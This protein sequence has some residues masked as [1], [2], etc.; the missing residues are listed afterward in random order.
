MS[1]LRAQPSESG[2]PKLASTDDLCSA[3]GITFSP[4][5][6]AAITAP[7]EPGVIIAGAG[8]GK[9]TVM[10]ARVV[11]LVGTGQVQP[12]QVLGLT[13]TRKAAAELSQ[14]VRS[15]L[16]RAG[17]VAVDGPDDAGEEVVMTYDAFAA[18]LV[19]DHGL[20]IAVETDPTMITGAAR[21][22][23]ASRAVTSASGPFEYLSRLRP[24]SV[25][26]RVLQLD[27][28]L[29]AHLV[30]RLEVVAFTDE[31]LR[32]LD[33]APQY[34]GRPY[35]IINQARAA[36]CE[37]VELLDL[38]TDYQALKRRLGLVEFADQMAVAA[39]L[40][41]RVP[42][43]ATAL[44]QQFRVVLLDEYQDTSAAQ[45][46]LLRGLFS[47]VDQHTGRG[48]PVTAVGDPWQAIYGWR[49]AAAS[50]ILT[51]A[52]AF[53]RSDGR[54]AHG[55]TL[56][57]NRRSGQEILDVA[58]LV[59]STLFDDPVLMAHR[60]AHV[61]IDLVAPAGTPPAS[62][63]AATFE[64][65]ADEVQFIADQIVDDHRS[66]R[67]TLWSD[68][69]VLS[70]RNADV[71]AMHAA[72]LSRD[73]PVEIVG[74]GGLLLLPEIAD[75]VATLTLIDD[76]TANPAV[77]R[78]LAG[79]R[80]RIG[81]RDLAALGQRAGELA[82]GGRPRG[83]SDA[84]AGPD[85]HSDVAEA[86]AD[87]DPADVVCLSDAIED[88]GDADLSPSARE[89]LTAFGVEMRRLRQHSGESV[90]D[91]TRRVIATLGLDVELIADSELMRTDRRSQLS[92]FVDAVASYSD[93]DGDDSLSGLLAWLDAELE[94]GAGLDQALPS[95]HNSV[96][97]LTV[98]RAKGLEWDVVYVPGLVVG[99]FPSDR[100]TNNW[101]TS[102]AN[103]PAP[104][105]GDADGVPQ[106]DEVSKVGFDTYKAALGEAERRSEDRL[107]YVALTRARRQ[108]TGTGH[109]WRATN[110]KPYKPSR[111]LQL[112]VAAASEQNRV[113]HLAPP[114]LAANPAGQ[115]T[116][117]HTWPPPPDAE[118][119]ERVH[120]AADQV[121]RA[122]ER[123]LTTGDA[124]AP[125][126]DPLPLDEAAIV[127][128]WDA[129][130]DRL[131]SQARAADTDTVQVTVPASLSA[132]A[133][134]SAMRDPGS[135][136]LSAL[137]PMPRPASTAA[138]VGSRFHEWVERR[139]R[140]PSEL[141][142]D[143]VV[144]LP[145][146]GGLPPG[147][148][149]PTPLLVD[150]TDWPS[151]ELSGGD[152]PLNRLIEAFLASEYADRVPEVIEYPFV[153]VLGRHQVRG[154]IDA[155][156]Q[157]QPGSGF[158]WQLVDWKTSGAP[159]DPV[160]LSLYRLA[161][162]QLRGVPIDHIDAVFMQVATG[163][164][165]R[166]KRLWSETELLAW[167]DHPGHATTTLTEPDSSPGPKDRLAA[168][169]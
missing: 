99:N 150:P 27:A 82:R 96:K 119:S 168:E 65:W 9:T 104:L 22:R 91:L 94:H 45:A 167:L 79:P 43:V 78:L 80:W 117:S 149:P 110:S 15:A 55:F 129:D 67:A 56:S 60:S 49:G 66:G 73:V 18:R 131:L 37:R 77:V 52:E 63:Q 90:L 116:A 124:E 160:Q 100:V 156:Y 31:F 133:M 5:Q 154:R 16:D 12:Q 46:A 144:S 29:S 111:Y 74:L 38:V 14:R 141:L 25:T 121:R 169:Q 53:P 145:G 158:D 120:D 115:L 48:H 166:P 64:S 62:V 164:V 105:R 127:A 118:R 68:I 57:V 161:W 58:N 152:T 51:F 153:L 13:F 155:V 84:E 23:L 137:R 93:V 42:G 165:V 138:T 89:R 44:R 122:T 157:A 34:R 41:R 59:A 163:R 4:E 30:R 75:V 19:A 69:A 114:V 112:L 126:L 36:A 72:L 76:V 81:P 24:R 88:L 130:M 148:Q 97:L 17:V 147:T 83:F 1:I 135:F 108:L 142:D 50:N 28:D 136:A 134:M 87:I 125:D 92:A 123:L 32:N 54:A 35:A 107:A 95:E 102:A 11:W 106:V 109:T 71:A 101:V 143:Q 103:L 39:E 21:F 86:L 7:L 146:G 162:S 61:P 113:L 151:P 140:T 98:H 3:L 6:L 70:R 40:V 10:A 47:G 8:S 33:S 20:R 128:E 159:A 132:S 2:Q 85:L 26:E 139:F